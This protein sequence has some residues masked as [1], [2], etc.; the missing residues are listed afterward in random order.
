MN[1]HRIDISGSWLYA[2]DS[3]T[4]YSIPLCMITQ[5]SVIHS[6]KTFSILANGTSIVYRGAE[7]EQ[8]FALLTD[9]LANQG[10]DGRY[11]AASRLSKP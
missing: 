5:V 10:F 11:M 6:K 8:A 1:V 9:A 3:W 2:Y 4:A 7:F